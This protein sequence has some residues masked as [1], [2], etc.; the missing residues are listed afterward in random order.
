MVNELTDATG[1]VSETQDVS[2]STVPTIGEQQP[3]VLPQVPSPQPQAQKDQTPNVRLSSKGVALNQGPVIIGRTKIMIPDEA[4]QRAGFYTEFAG[5]LV[6]QY[7]DYKFIQEKGQP[8]TQGVSI[9]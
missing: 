4:T 3:P 2:S 7:R 5:E 9:S 1:S 6:A 8:N